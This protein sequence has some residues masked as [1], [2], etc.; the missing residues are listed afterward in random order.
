MLNRRVFL[1]SGLATCSV[2]W[3]ATADGSSGPL[4]AAAAVATPPLYC[5]VVDDRFQCG[6][7]FRAGV[8][9]GGIAVRRIRGDVT[10]LW[11]HELAPR[12]RVQP[13]PIAGLT[14]ADAL[15]CLER[16]AWDAGLR[17][18]YRGEH[19]RLADGSLQHRLRGSSSA[20]A[21]APALSSVHGNW[22][23]CIARL[24]LACPRYAPSRLALMIVNCRQAAPASALPLYSWLIAARAPQRSSLPEGEQ[25]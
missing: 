22:E 4:D 25:L 17:V 8:A 7:G 3:L 18:A 15:F 10:E 24:V 13:A 21:A 12:W 1:E 11:F 6:A 2:P 14:A 5:V 20:L 23:A 16:L 9:S 19:R